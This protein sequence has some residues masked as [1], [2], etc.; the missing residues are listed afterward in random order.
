MTTDDRSAQ[1]K[2]G[3]VDLQALY[4]TRRERLPEDV[5]K[6]L[7]ARPW[8]LALSGGGI[9][10][11][12]F[13]FGLIKALAEKELLH[14]FD[15]MS[16]VS[17]GGYIGSTI[18]KL[19]HN[20]GQSGAPDPMRLERE[21][22]QAQTRWFAVWLRANGRYLIPRGLKDILFAAANFGRNLLGVHVELAFLA[23]ILGGFLVSLDLAVWQWVDCLAPGGGCAPMPWLDMGLIGFFSDWPTI[24]LGLVPVAWIGAILSCTYWALPTRKGQRLGVQRLLTALMASAG[25]VILLRH[26][27]DFLN[28]VIPL[29]TGTLELPGGLVVLALALMVAWVLG[30]LIAMCLSIKSEKD[31]DR[32]RNGLTQGLAVALKVALAFVVL[33]MVDY[34]AWSLT[35]SN[36]T[37]QGQ[38]GG[39]LALIA[40][41]LRAAMPMIADLPK[42]LVPGTR[43]VVMEV[44]NVLGV[45]LAGALLVFWISVLHR[46]TTSVLFDSSLG[47]LHFSFAWQYLAWLTI[48]PL[49]MVLVSA[50]NRDFLNRSSLYAFY[51]A[52]LIRSYL[53]AANPNRFQAAT[54]SPMSCV[55]PA[56]SQTLP[57]R[58][59]QVDD[60]DD[61]TMVAY[62]PHKGGGPVHLINVCVNQTEDPMG[63]LFNQDRK[64]SLLTVGPGGCL[65]HGSD[66]WHPGSQAQS[67]SL[68][69][70]VAISGAA[71]APGLGKS[72]RSGIAALLMMSGIRLGY[73]WDSHGMGG[74][75]PAKRIG[76][77]GQLLSELRGRF[78]GDRRQDWFL[79]DGGHFENTA[80]YALLRE[81]CEVI[82]VADC[83]ADPRYAFGD[84]ENLVRKA[85]IDLQAEITFLRPR[86]PDR[87]LP[88]V[89]G[90]LNELASPDSEAC[91]ALAR[92]DYRRS[93]RSGYMIIVKP[94]MSNGAPVDLV[95]FKSD[96]PLFPQEPTTDQSFSEAQWESYFQLGQTLGR[97]LDLEQLQDMRAFAKNYFVNDD[98][99]IL[100]KESDGAMVLR[101]SSKRLS[102]RIASTGAVSASIS[103]GAITSI[104]LAGWQAINSEL[105]H[106]VDQ[107]KIEPGALKELTDIFGKLPP[108]GR[109]SA[110][111][112]NDPLG[113]MATALLRVGDKACTAY[114]LDAFRHSAL[115]KLMVSR[116]KEAC[117]QS[118]SAHPSCAVLLDDF[119]LSACL[120]DEPRGKCEPQYWI[121]DYSSAT[122]ISANCWAPARDYVDQGEFE[123]ASS[124]PAPAPA[125]APMPELELESSAPAP[126]PD[127]ATIQEHNTAS[128]EATPVEDTTDICKGQTVYLQIHGP[129]LRD[130]ARTLRGP[131]RSFGASVP[132]VEDVV[133]SARRANRRAPTPY[134]SPIVIYHN[135]ASKGCAEKLISIE[136][137]KSW[138]IAPLADGLK[139]QKGVIEVWLPP[140]TK[141]PL[142]KAF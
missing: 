24:W 114:N 129:E 119:S 33:G 87:D 43:R 7:S 10:S 80:A 59:T 92:V 58:V 112:S 109:Q 3:E 117:R 135:A 64:G 127:E 99:A 82:V 17:G 1:S 20:E 27:T 55:A 124:S 48:P 61:L 54:P 106:R 130:F 13:C 62:Q 71:V 98:G 125:P 115:M 85:R 5:Q 138:G 84:L 91:L 53:G 50:A 67:L 107:Q 104:G 105:T 102:S 22:G 56:N 30:I 128:V 45:A 89:F 83:G 69:A 18:G 25:I 26:S 72:T 42:S 68:G 118:V 122:L 131:W 140:S 70:W 81:E 96:N 14:R 121:R 66:T 116:T 37:S 44:I 8:G 74:Q 126:A 63:G 11:A 94:N 36:T 23:F 12:T 31:P 39:M 75:P 32:T 51:R 136:A 142:D 90:S 40:I 4:Q 93:G 49:L 38:L 28:N 86:Q 141:V 103:L 65:L 16:T 133:D 57:L 97:N 79:S 95:N 113:E 134:P 73:W 35:N 132:P 100:I 110:P 52:R 88:A 9:R 108:L 47:A 120:Q 6:T 101:F 123:L 29:W 60:G 137:A 78:D 111:S 77:Y 15:L 19:F 41:A 34:L 2:I 21:L 76:K 46:A 139:G